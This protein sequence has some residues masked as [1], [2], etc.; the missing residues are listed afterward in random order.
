MGYWVSIGNQER[1]V[2]EPRDFDGYWGRAYSEILIDLKYLRKGQ[3]LAYKGVGDLLTA[4]VF[5]AWLITLETFL[6]QR[7]FQVSWRM[8]VSR[9]QNTTMQQVS[10][11]NLS[12]W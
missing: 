12:N 8:E 1:Y 2:S 4:Y 6:I 3:S 9:H 7:P 10:M 5:K 11:Q